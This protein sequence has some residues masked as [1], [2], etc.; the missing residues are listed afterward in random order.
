MACSVGC[1]TKGACVSCGFLEVK[2][3][4]NDMLP[5]GKRANENIYEVRFKTTRKGFY[6]NEKAWPITIGDYVVV[7]GDIER[8]PD[9]YDVGIVVS[10]GVVALRQL[11]KRQKHKPVEIKKIIR[12]ATQRDIERLKRL[13]SKEYA[14]LLRTRE[15]V[16]EM[17]LPMKMTDVEY[18]GD[19]TKAIFYYIADGRI[20]FRELVKVLAREFRL[21]IQMHQIG[22]RQEAGLVGGYGTCGRPLCCSTFLTQFKSVMLAAPRLQGIA[23][24]PEKLTGLCKRLK[25]CLNY[26]L[27][28]YLEAWLQIPDIKE[29]ETDKGLVVRKKVNILQ[30]LVWYGYAEGDGG[31]HSWICL[32]I[33]Q[34]SLLERLLKE[35]K[36]FESLEA[37]ASVVLNG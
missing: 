17:G 6:K 27:D 18:Q 29:I 10:G 20:D 34:M 2:D 13:R 35:G 7:E 15:I 1:L 19:G 8:H 22:V 33:K 12:P 11:E 3:W 37:I 25:C 36:R 9:S 5:A 31:S 21:R 30:R 14:M 32:D 23:L 4:F 28:Q 24:N 26:E 16:K